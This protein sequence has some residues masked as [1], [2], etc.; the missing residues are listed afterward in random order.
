MMELAHKWDHSDVKTGV[1]FVCDRHGA[2]MI[3]DDCNFNEL[4]DPGHYSVVSL[5]HAGVLQDS[6]AHGSSTK[7]AEHLTKLNA[8]PVHSDESIT[9]SGT[10]PPPKLPKGVN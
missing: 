2:C 9:L 7:V 1:I 6:D 10:T 5:D 4:H 3:I 8:R